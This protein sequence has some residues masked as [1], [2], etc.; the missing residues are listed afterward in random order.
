M[1]TE[2]SK[3]RAP[4]ENREGRGTVRPTR[5]SESARPCWYAVRGVRVRQDITRMDRDVR[6]CGCPG[7]V[8]LDRVETWDEM[9]RV[10]VNRCSCG[11][12]WMW[13]RR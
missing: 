6:R 3:G 12:T 5:I 4:V 2:N 1:T 11:A 7:S 13:G 10:R 9:L 8:I